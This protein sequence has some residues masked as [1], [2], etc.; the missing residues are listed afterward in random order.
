MLGC[1]SNDISPNDNLNKN[2][3]TSQIYIKLNL[4]GIEYDYPVYDASI[5]IDEETKKTDSSGQAEFE[6]D[7]KG[8]STNIETYHSNITYKIS[9]KD[10]SII[11]IPLFLPDIIEDD[12]LKNIL[13]WN[14]NYNARWRI[15]KYYVYFDF[16]EASSSITEENK[17]NIKNQAMQEIQQWE[18]VPGMDYIKTDNNEEPDI[19]VKI[20]TDTNYFNLF[21]DDEDSNVA[22]RGGFS[23]SSQNSYFNYVGNIWIRENYS[24]QQ[25]LYTHEMGHV[26]GFGHPEYLY[27]SDSVMSYQNDVQ[28]AGPTEIDKVLLRLKMNLNPMEY[29]SPIS[30]NIT[31]MSGSHSMP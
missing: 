29:Y 25:G 10:T 15:K 13:F 6:L 24:T 26:M 20:M 19:F 8:Y 1:S 14:G 16:S 22:G 28:A 5:T 12:H 17:N 3:K 18:L 9:V 11:D 30:N 31:K 4:K 23:W 21:P 27:S 7:H 2:I